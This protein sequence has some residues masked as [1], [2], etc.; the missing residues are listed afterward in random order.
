M[1]VI[2]LRDTRADQAYFDHAVEYLATRCES[3]DRRLERPVE[4]WA[5]PRRIGQVAGD[6]LKQRWDR[7][8]ALYSQGA[9]VEVLRAEFDSVL[10]DA[11]RALRLSKEFLSAEQKAARFRVDNNK[12]SYRERLELVALALAF[13]VD[14]ATF[15]RVV[16]AVEVAWGD[17]LVDRLIAIRRPSHPVGDVLAFPEIVGALNDA[18]DS[19]DR[20]QA[21]ARYLDG[22]YE[23]WKGIWGWGGH[24]SIDK[25]VYKG[26]WA[27]EA[28]GVVAAL[29]IDDAVFRDNEY[30]PG[31]LATEGAAHDR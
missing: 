13:R 23:A 1:D 12:D 6:V 14:E 15:D 18:F 3:N 5:D 17:Q 16:A 26:Y 29:G 24:L 2:V 10:S 11:E 7:F 28:L 30:Y 27:F 4:K 8:S 31:D 20:A 19:A 25:G 22:W 9:C 21:V